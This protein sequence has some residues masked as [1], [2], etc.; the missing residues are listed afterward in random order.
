MNIQINI[1]RSSY[2]NILLIF[3]RVA[4]KSNSADN[5]MNGVTSFFHHQACMYQVLFRSDISFL[6]YRAETKKVWNVCFIF[7]SGSKWSLVHTCLMVRGRNLWILSFVSQRSRSQLLRIEQ[8]FYTF[9][10]L[11]NLVKNSQV[12]MYQITDLFLEIV[13]LTFDPQTSSSWD[14]F[15]SAW[16]MCVLSFLAKIDIQGKHDVTN[17]SMSSK[18]TTELHFQKG[19]GHNFQRN[20]TKIVPNLAKNPQT[21]FWL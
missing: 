10:C 17:S 21:M 11:P 20:R 7:R 19:Q 18:I 15:L 13:I 6:R 3:S 16:G 12:K 5:M 1:C 2:C 9:F 14:L 4:T 8:Q